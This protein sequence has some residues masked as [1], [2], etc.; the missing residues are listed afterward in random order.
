MRLR[1][2][3]DF[4]REKAGGYCNQIYHRGAGACVAFY[5]PMFSRGCARASRKSQAFL[6]ICCARDAPLHADRAAITFTVGAQRAAPGI[7]TWPLSPDPPS[8]VRFFFCHAAEDAYTAASHRSKITPRIDF[9]RGAL[10][11]LPVRLTPSPMFSRLMLALRLKILRTEHLLY[12]R[13][14]RCSRPFPYNLQHGLRVLRA[15]V[16]NLFPKMRDESA[17]RHRN[18]LV[19]IEFRSRAHPPRPRNHCDEP[20]VRMP[21]RTA[22]V[23]RSPFR[24][25]HVKSRLRRIARQDRHLR[26]DRIVLPLNLVW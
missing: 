13:R 4:R 17:G 7:N 10:P 1:T 23:I 15:V 12:F 19:W 21:V 24:Q 11:N 18:R 6:C 14:C 3:H 26:P 2:P 8:R 25:H 5:V 16:M 9:E 20:V 22:H